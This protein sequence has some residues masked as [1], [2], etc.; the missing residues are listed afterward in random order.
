MFAYCLNNPIISSDNNGAISFFSVCLFDDVINFQIVDYVIVYY[1]QNS[2]LNLD[3]QAYGQQYSSEAI[4]VD[5]SSYSDFVNAMK[6]IPS[7]HVNNIYLYLHSDYDNEKED[8]R[9]V[10][11]YAKY[12]YAENILSDISPISIQGDIYLFSCHGANLAPS[13]AQ[14]T[15]KNVVA[16]YEGVSFSSGYARIGNKDYFLSWLYGDDT[17]GWWSFSPSGEA[18]QL[19]QG[20]FFYGG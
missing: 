19:T 11:Y 17:R 8:Y 1:N 4:Y 18:K 15:G 7:R 2:Q 13:L 12:S 10:F 20:Q 14:A 6:S 16:S 3:G 5:V 9:F